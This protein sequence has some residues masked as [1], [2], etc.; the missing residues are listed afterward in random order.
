ML[1]AGVSVS[2]ASRRSPIELVGE[3]EGRRVREHRDIEAFYGRSEPGSA[4]SGDDEWRGAEIRIAVLGARQPVAPQRG[5]DPAAECPARPGGGV[6][7]DRRGGT[8]Y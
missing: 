8:D 7:H 1:A 5:L 3:A 6:C 4:R 2:C